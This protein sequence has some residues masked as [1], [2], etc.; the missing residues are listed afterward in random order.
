MRALNPAIQV[1]APWTTGTLAL[2]DLRE[3]AYS[4]G[5]QIPPAVQGGV[6]VEANIWERLV[7]LDAQSPRTELSE[8]LYMLT[9]APRDGPDQPAC[10]DIEL[11][12]GIPVRVNGIEMS[13]LE[14]IESLDTIGG[15]HGVGR[16]D[17]VVTRL[18]GRQIRIVREAPAATILQMAHREL[19]WMH[20][21]PE[22][23][24]MASNVGDAYAEMIRTGGWF[25]RRRVAMDGFTA[26]IQPFVTGTIRL[27]LLKGDCRVVRRTTP[28]AGSDRRPA[29]APA[30]LSRATG[31]L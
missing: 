26:A 11:E 15:T 20:I 18:D 13:L 24:R 21:E 28:S 19:E 16:G 8:D 5:V 17:I 22:L 27:D 6:E 12:N 29:V 1:L 10:V 9:R 30:E 3:Y 25:S 23:A 14:M 7:M 31:A 4:R 2:P